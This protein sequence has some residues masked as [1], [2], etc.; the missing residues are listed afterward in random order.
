[1]REVNDDDEE[2]GDK[3]KRSYGCKVKKLELA[4]VA[5]LAKFPFFPK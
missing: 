4:L 2:Q 1:M 5:T 3:K